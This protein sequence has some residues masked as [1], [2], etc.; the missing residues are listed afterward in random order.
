MDG[1]LDWFAADVTRD[2]LHGVL[3][4]EARDDDEWPN[5]AMR[6]VAV[7]RARQKAD[8]LLTV[9]DRDFLPGTG[10]PFL[11]GAAPCLADY[12]GAS[13]LAAGVMARYDI[14]RWPGI[15]AWL[16][17]MRGLPAWR[18]IARQVS[19]A[20]RVPVLSRLSSAA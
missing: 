17:A 7:Q 20:M 18:G 11:G 5:P 4:A 2:V 6:A 19:W 12:L 3:L 9:L 16:R 15:A 13:I 10:G 1:L 14:G 8:Q